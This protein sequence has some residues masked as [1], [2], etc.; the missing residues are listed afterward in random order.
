MDGSVGVKKQREP[1]GMVPGSVV[2]RTIALLLNFRNSS[3][4]VS[5]WRQVSNRIL[6]LRER[7][8]SENF[9][10]LT[11]RGEWP[12]LARMREVCISAKPKIIGDVGN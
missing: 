5:K 1:G 7:A 6:Y 4:R 3:R 2:W 8:A 10:C 9:H 12:K 11:R